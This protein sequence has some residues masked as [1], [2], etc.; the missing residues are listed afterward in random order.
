MEISKHGGG[1]DNQDQAWRWFP[2]A[3]AVVGRGAAAAEPFRG[4]RP[5][6]GS[7]HGPIDH[8]L[9]AGAAR[10][11]TFWPPTVRVSPEHIYR[12][13]VPSKINF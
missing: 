1:L 10:H 9:R 4:E 7:G 6:A 5:A 3:W 12:S 8:R 2:S 13:P 11:D